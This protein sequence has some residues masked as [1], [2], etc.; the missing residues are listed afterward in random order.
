MNPYLNRVMIQD[1]RHFFGR[2]S[3]VRRILAR[4]GADRPQ[5]ISIVGERRIG[6]SSL[7]AYL[8]CAEVQ[9]RHQVDRS[10]LA[11]VFLDFQQLRSISVEDFFDF[12][13]GR[14]RHVSGEGP[15]AA[16][17][18]Y[19]AFQGLLENLRGQ[20]KKLVLLFDE[21]QAITSNTAFNIEFY[22]FLRSMANNYAVA[23]VTTSSVDL[24]RLCCSSDISDSPFFNIFSNLYLKTFEREEAL[25]LICRPSEENG[26]P[27]RKYAD[28]IMDL[29]GLFPFYLQIACSIYFDSLRG[30]PGRELDR[31]EI[32]S[33]FQ[34]EA[35]PH[36]DYFWEHAA[37]EC[38]SLLE[39]LAH[40]RQPDPSEMHV[41][42]GLVR[43]GY[44]AQVGERWR[45]FSSAFAEHI[46]VAAT[47]SAQKARMYAPAGSAPNH[48]IGPGVRVHQYQILRKAGEGGMGVVFLAEDTALGRKVALKFVKPAMVQDEMSRRRFLQ[49]ARSAAGLNHPAI[50]LVYEL[51]EYGPH[52]GLAL[53][54]IEGTT[55]KQRILKAGR[56]ELRQAV[57]WMTEALDGLGDA[58]EHGVIHRDINS[59]NLM[60]TAQNHVKIMD[61]GLA[62]SRGAEIEKTLTAIT[63]AGALMGTID[64]MSPEQARGVPVDIRS[65]LFSLGVV[66]FE[67]LTGELP[68]KGD[69]AIDT[70]QCITRKP[71]PSMSSYGIERGDSVDRLLRKLLAKSPDK[72]HVSAAELKAEV[73]RLLKD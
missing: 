53:E 38:Q 73:E 51:F 33:R 49:E 15:A 8:T 47:E 56:I 69:S 4:L 13:L 43:K 37:P 57:A 70:L 55:L 58:H 29:A 12:L 45:L 63:A 28:E 68:F 59:S 6:K 32:K 50:A 14:I 1:P 3:E 42:Q 40:D 35:G 64:Y 41:C 21:F 9:D 25:E 71:V 44:L 60:V 17:H 27:L 23:Y 19:A 65:D 36:F 39:N 30:G 22:S 18:G 16:A 46:R 62:H 54:W 2:R 34:E 11:I 10:S 26:V 66:F 72:R 48:P 52:F 5:S 24:Q 31:E 67:A 7:L 61:F 20:S